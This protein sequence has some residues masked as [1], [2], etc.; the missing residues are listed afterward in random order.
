VY[1]HVFLKLLFKNLLLASKLITDENI[2]AI[3]GVKLIISGKIKGKPRST[4]TCIQVG[5]V[6]SQSLAKDIS[7]SKIHV[8]TLY[9]SFGFKIWVHKK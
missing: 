1:K 7:F 9:G 5:S 4:T 2:K 6:P 8:Y 3:L